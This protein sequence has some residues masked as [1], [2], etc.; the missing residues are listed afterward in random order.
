[1]KDI[2][3]I[4]IKFANGEKVNPLVSKY[5][6]YIASAD[7]IA[8]TYYFDKE[9]LNNMKNTVISSPVLAGF[10]DNDDGSLLGG[11][12][13]DISRT[14]KG[15]RR[16]PKPIAVGYVLDIEPWWENYDGKEWLTCYVH[17]WDYKYSGLQNLSER[18]IFQ[19]MEV[20]L[21]DI[22]ES[23]YRKVTNAIL[24]G[25][26]ILENVNPAFNGS[27]F[28]KINFSKYDFKGDIDKLKEEFNTFGK[29]ENLDFTIPE[30]VKKQAKK[31]LELRK[32]YN[33][34]G[35]SVGLAT[36][37]YLISNKT[38]SPEKVRHISKYFPRHEGDNLDENGRNG[39]ELSN[40]YIAWNL[41]GSDAGRKWSNNLVNKMNEADEEDK[42]FISKGG[43][44]VF[45]GLTSNQ[46]RRRLESC[47]SQ[48]KYEQGEYEYNKYWMDDF[49]DFGIFVH[50]NEDGNCY[51]M[52]YKME[53]NI[54]CVDIDSK[55]PVETGYKPISFAEKIETFL[56]KDEYGTDEKLDVD[57]TKESASNEDWGSINK[58]QLRNKIAKASNW[59]TLKNKCY[60]ISEG[61]NAS[62]WKY[63]ICQIKDNK[64]VY[65][66][67]GV[68]TAWT[69]LAKE[70]N[71][72]YFT[73]VK[74]E[75]K[76]I[77]KKLGL[78]MNSFSERIGEKMTDYKAMYSKMKAEKSNFMLADSESFALMD[79]EFCCIYAITEDGIIKIPF[80][81]AENDEN[82]FS[83]KEDITEN[84]SDSK[85]LMCKMSKLIKGEKEKS[86]MKDVEM[87]KVLANM[88]SMES[89]IKDSDSL[90]EE[91]DKKIA[92]LENKIKEK[93]DQEKMSKVN[94][95]LSKKEFSVF[96]QEEKEEFSKQAQLLALGE[97]ENLLY[98]TFGK[99]IKD[100]IDFSSET[101]KF[102]YMYV[103]I[104][105][106]KSSFNESKDI[107]DEI[108]E[109]NNLTK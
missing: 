26:C 104:T 69:M 44:N 34:G 90:I 91:K 5:K 39:K 50:D 1:M 12:E 21:E 74:T 94:E 61:E 30:E 105:E 54:C 62:D 109:K 106:N 100:N 29:Y 81:V 17:I 35:T 40:G 67:N 25:L 63:P 43:E 102:S 84:M 2:I 13:D 9:V 22:K 96:T 98:S 60:L 87:G 49:N 6:C 16:T 78:N 76:K 59:K 7:T 36:A 101:Q 108:R 73:S 77:Y 85:E 51:S 48:Y 72:S 19:S 31:G 95:M 89:K 66:I 3:N 68:Q 52:N 4:N 83:L 57:L 58:T 38:A 93:D 88:A 24:T 23:K 64:L 42:N 18:K 82:T 11:H 46:L 103:P 8:N 47:L 97:F 75:I 53:N 32:K 15:L 33:R 37:R 80:E 107:Y 10:I 79:G 99:K 92:D 70:N 14:E 71:E 45:Y 86:T 28:E 20:Q 65:N 55:I 27:T 41:W 56:N